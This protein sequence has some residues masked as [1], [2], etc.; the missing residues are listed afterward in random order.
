MIAR[1]TKK[2]KTNPDLLLELLQSPSILGET[3]LDGLRLL[4]SRFEVGDLELNRVDPVSVLLKLLL[5]KF[6]LGGGFRESGGE[7]FA[8]SRKK[9]ATLEPVRERTS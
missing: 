7:G 5:E 4:E 2:T 6:R 3:L 9:E 1:E 8:V